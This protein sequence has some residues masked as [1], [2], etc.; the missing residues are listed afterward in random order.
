MWSRVNVS[1]LIK[2]NILLNSLNGFL[3]VIAIC[4]LDGCVKMPPEKLILPDICEGKSLN[5]K[6]AGCNRHCHG[7]EPR[8]CYHAIMVV[9][10]TD[11]DNSDLEERLQLFHVLRSQTQSVMID[12]HESSD[13]S[14]GWRLWLL[15][16]STGDSMIQSRGQDRRQRGQAK[17]HFC[18]TYLSSILLSL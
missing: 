4:C 1:F 17:W 8:S 5:V 13:G 2:W 14:F 11:G 16:V 6:A 18:N 7:H 3:A 10:K 15:V 9:A 12:L